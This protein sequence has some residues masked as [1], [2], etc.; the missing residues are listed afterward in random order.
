MTNTS[1]NSTLYKELA[2]LRDI[3]H[4]DGAMSWGDCAFLAENQTEIK[5]FFPDDALLWECAGIPE[6]EWNERG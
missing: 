6:S 3:V 1:R 4:A 2:R 5:E